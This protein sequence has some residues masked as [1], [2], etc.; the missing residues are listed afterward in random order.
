MPPPVEPLVGR[1]RLLEALTARARPGALL[2]LLGPA[3]VGKSAL[4]RAL[5]GPEATAWV[6]LDGVRDPDDAVM[7]VA[8]ALDV[9]IRGA[10]DRGSVAPRLA[11]R[12]RAPGLL[13][14]DGCEGLAERPE[15]WLDG[16][17]RGGRLR[18][19]ATSRA[20]LGAP[21]ESILSVEPL[22][23]EAAA[24]LFLDVAGSRGA[25]VEPSDALDAL[26]VALDHLPLAI[27]LA[28]PWAQLL[29]VP[30][31]LERVRAERFRLLKGPTGSML[32]AMEASFALLDDVEREALRQLQVASGGFDVAAAE[33]I[34]D[35][36]GAWPLE[37]LARLVDRC[38][39]RASGPERR[40][41]IDEH[42]RAWL[43]TR[44]APDPAAR[45]RHAE[46]HAALGERLNE[47]MY[48]PDGGAHLARLKQERSNLLAAAAAMAEADPRL[49][50]RCVLAAAP[51][52]ARLGFD[53]EQGWLDRAVTLASTRE[54]RLAALHQRGHSLSWWLRLDEARRDLEEA[55]RLAEGPR[56]RLESLGF[57]GA[58]AGQSGH[59]ERALRHFEA[60]AAVCRAHPPLEPRLAMC[61]AMA[62]RAAVSAGRPAQ[63]L[64]L[65][66]EALALL[67]VH[68][69]D[70]ARVEALV[71][72]SEALLDRDPERAREAGRAAFDAAE[73]FGEGTHRVAAAMAWAR[74]LA[75]TGA[76][77]EAV[78]LLS[79]QH[80]RTPRMSPGDREALTACRAALD[81]APAAAAVAV[82][83]D[84]EA[85]VVG[86]RR[87]DLGRRG[88][89][90]RIV[91]ALLEAD[92]PLATHELFEH[93]WPGERV[94]HEVM[95]N[96]VYVTV[97]KLRALGLG[98]RLRTTDAG[99]EL[100]DAP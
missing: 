16:W 32:A 59:H 70:F 92:R 100:C 38:W 84:G 61:L 46:H 60:A 71:S 82:A 22:A 4:A 66:E 65:L 15:A 27:E 69:D 99:Y 95:T 31:L 42:A 96:R 67:D 52:L 98:E 97:R 68:P 25:R 24:R 41:S 54:E 86:D 44:G 77:A 50:L 26:L 43:A 76:R 62:G 19:V 29:P 34:L 94:D 13:V 55:A 53:A 9:S 83:L 10:A 90:R 63:A 74:A 93:G 3:G 49:A 36:P 47:A 35:L 40:L 23:P 11:S 80:Q 73:R 48:G 91:A 8:E 30:A 45:R 18:V 20:R 56:E 28:A 37:V 17:W 33:A 6:A 1:E 87:V 5:G 58:L 85:L 64:P 7:R 88:P 12:A 51:V 79:T 14:L 39:L 2:T 57:L 78:D 89:M 81:A 21:G 75:A 72:R